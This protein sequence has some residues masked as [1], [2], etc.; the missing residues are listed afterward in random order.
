MIAATQCVDQIPT[1]E[2]T[3][4]TLTY[5]ALVMS[6]KPWK[7]LVTVR[8]SD[9][10]SSQSKESV[11]D[12]K[13]ELPCDIQAV[14]FYTVIMPNKLSAVQFL[15]LA[16]DDPQTRTSVVGLMWHLSW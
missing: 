16:A 15:T 14:T 10:I 3:S 13:E 4:A 2:I 1:V 7:G 11:L 12:E 8:K 6:A 9:Y 5:F